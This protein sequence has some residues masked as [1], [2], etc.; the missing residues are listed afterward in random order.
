MNELLC[1]I[2]PHPSKKISDAIQGKDGYINMTIGSPHFDPPKK[3]LDSLKIIIQGNDK[4][5]NKYAHSRGCYLLR[6]AIAERYEYKYNIKLNPDNQVL[7]TNGCAEAIWLTIFTATNIGDE[8][9]IP[10]P[11]YVLY[12]PIIVS[13]GR[14]PIRFPT[15]HLNGF[16]L[17]IESILKCITSKTK[18]IIINSPCNPTG[19]VYTVETLRKLCKIVIKKNIYLMQDEVFDD[20]IF[21]KQSHTTILKTCKNLKNLIVVNS[22]SK[23]LG[24]TGW[25][26]GWLVASE[27]FTTQAVKAHTFHCLAVNTL[28]QT[29][30]AMVMNDQEVIDEIQ[31]NGL[32]LEKNMTNFFSLIQKIDGFDFHKIPDAGMYLF[33]N[34]SNLYQNIPDN[35][36][37]GTKSEAVANFILEKSHIAVVPGSAFGKNGENHI[38]IS[39]AGSEKDLLEAIKRF[40]TQL[41]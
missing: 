13:L 21:N 6:S 34:I 35:Y 8:V 16:Q 2:P 1:T 40:N 3:I 7:I 36:K 9:I 38:R 39:I 28:I 10:D 33:P 37:I 30:V 20:F 29:A 25:R 14:Y 17:D 23:R 4:T 22:F 31:N 19:T 26:L 32:L 15:S 41:M 11:C 12:E 5:Y 24:I 18:L 27:E